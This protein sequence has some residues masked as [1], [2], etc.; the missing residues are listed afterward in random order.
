MK[1]KTINLYSLDELSKEAQ[2]KAHQ[3][4]IEN[5][6]MPFLS[7]DMTEYLKELLKENNLTY[8][9]VPKV[10]Y[11]L[12]YCQGD[13]AMF[14]GTVYYGAI[15]ARIKHSGHYYHYNSKELDLTMTRTGNE[16]PESSY[17]KFN[18]IYVDICEQL[19][20][21]G[22]AEIEDKQ[23]FEYFKDIC[24]ANDYTFTSKGKME[25]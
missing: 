18:N 1:T 9:E 2:E 15:T 4:W 19:A 11:S 6:D 21:Y 14:E 25:N 7:E 16:A 24:E 5:D 17:L 13:G 8:D 3:E 20:K 12:S 22:Y 10:Y 23:S